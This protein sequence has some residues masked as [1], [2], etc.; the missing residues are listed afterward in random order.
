MVG[1]GKNICQVM[2]WMIFAYLNPSHFKSF[3]DNGTFNIFDS[4]WWRVNNQNT[5]PLAGRRA[6][7][8]S[9]FWEIM[10]FFFTKLMIFAYLNPSHFKSF[11]DNSTFNIFD[12]DWGCVDTQNVGAFL[13]RWANPPSKFW[14]IVGL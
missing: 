6:K 12:G 1:K 13:G 8:P 4:D 5:S 7:P 11:I 9:K 3:I 2:S 14:E 10:V